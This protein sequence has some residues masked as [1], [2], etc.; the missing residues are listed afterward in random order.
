MEYAFLSCFLLI[1]GDNLFLHL[2]HQPGFKGGSEWKTAHQLGSTNDVGTCITFSLP[3]LELLGIHLMQKTRILGQGR[4]AARFVTRLPR[5][6]SAVARAIRWTKVKSSI[7]MDQAMDGLK[8]RR[9]FIRAVGV[10]PENSFCMT[11]DL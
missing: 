2:Q 9:S 11:Y 6:A 3:N 7:Q 5:S 1:H 8:P 10:C 4:Q